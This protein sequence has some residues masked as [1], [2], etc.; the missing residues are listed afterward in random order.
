M[1]PKSPKRT[2]P[3]VTAKRAETP[4]S[5][6]ARRREEER[7]ADEDDD[8][9]ETEEEESEDLRLQGMDGLSTAD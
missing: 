8:A 5:E 3:K 4:R 1:A 6:H 2:T 7:D 9:N